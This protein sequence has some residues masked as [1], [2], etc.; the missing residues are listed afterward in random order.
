MVQHKLN[1]ESFVIFIC[2]FIILLMQFQSDIVIG[3]YSIISNFVKS[4]R[5][6]KKFLSIHII[7]YRFSLETIM[8][9]TWIFRSNFIFLW[10]KRTNCWWLL[11][12]K[13]AFHVE[14]KSIIQKQRVRWTVDSSIVRYQRWLSYDCVLC[15]RQRTNAKHNLSFVFGF[16]APKYRNHAVVGKRQVEYISPIFC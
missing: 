8:E 11:S 16:C 13:T 1:Y 5:S 2:Q 7:G 15:V 10:H 9:S 4:H 12:I 3:N 14:D 6:G